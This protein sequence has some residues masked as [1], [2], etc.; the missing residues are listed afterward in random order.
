MFL[1]NFYKKSRGKKNLQIKC[2]LCYS[3]REAVSGSSRKKTQLK[4]QTT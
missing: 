2:V 1:Y 4:A 3:R